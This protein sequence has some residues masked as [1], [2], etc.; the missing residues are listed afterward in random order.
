MIQNIYVLL[1]L[2]IL[3]FASGCGN[4]DPK[5]PAEHLTS[6][7][8]KLSEV[9]QSP[10]VDDEE[11]R[12]LSVVVK[13][14]FEIW[15]RYDSTVDG[16]VLNRFTR[17][18]DS[19]ALQLSS[20][21]FMETDPDKIVSALNNQIFN[22]WDMEFDPDRNNV[23]SLFP[24]TS[25]EQKRGSCV[26]MSLLY[27]LIA[28]KCDWP[29]YGVLAPSHLFVRFDNGSTRRN[30]ETLRKGETMSSEWYA[31]KYSIKDTAY[32]PLDNLNRKE[33]QAVLYFNIGTLFY[34]R[35]EYQRSVEYLNKALSLMKYL[36]D[37]QGNLALAYEALGQPERALKILNDLAEWYPDF[38][39]IKKN[40]ASLQLRSGRFKEAYT[41]YIR[42][43]KFNRNDPDIF[44]GLAIAL[45]RLDRGAEAAESLA[46]TLELNP[47]HKPAR[48]LERK[49]ASA[50]E[51]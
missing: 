27:L 13:E 32:Y 8:K 40:I 7:Q 46:R 45:Y 18:L 42:L 41:S 43:S 28:E 17:K 37:A 20:T 22:E 2:M 35:K 9:M 26:G 33:L 39:N 31:E 4:N 44:Y 25:L 51:S 15:I 3:F 11:Q 21:L 47:N 6:E 1:L 34:G 14:L 23:R 16:L 10:V 12:P 29:F 48:D 19:S 36:P 50:S 5:E 49:I 38:R 24:Y 30:I